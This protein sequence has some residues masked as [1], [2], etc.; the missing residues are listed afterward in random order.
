MAS[1]DKIYG[2]QEQFEDFKAWL[3]PRKPEW[4]KYLY[5]DNGY[6]DIQRPISNFPT[7]CDAWLLDNCPMEW[8]TDRI[9]EQY[10]CN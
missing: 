10:G 6:K 9:K 8:V 4:R 2:T 7:E 5:L 1:I 3:L